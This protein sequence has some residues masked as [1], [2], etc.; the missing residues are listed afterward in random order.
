M[1]LLP[2]AQF[3]YN[4]LITEI[5]LITL[6]YANFGYELIVYKEPGITQVN[7]QLAQLQI[8]EIKTLHK[9]LAEEL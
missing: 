4:S 3:V 7:N 8:D 2:L 6:F 1:Q 9:T 5:T